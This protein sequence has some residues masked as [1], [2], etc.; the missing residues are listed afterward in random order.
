MPTSYPNQISTI[1]KLITKLNPNS[2]LDVGVGFGKYGVLCREYLELNEDKP[3]YNKFVKKIDGIEVYEK[4]LT[5]LHNY[6]YDHVYVGNV[7]NLIDQMNY[8]Y[9]LV[10]LIDIIEHFDKQQGKN[11]IKKLLKQNKGI[12]ISTPK[13]VSK[14][15]S[16]Y[17]NIY[18]THKSRWTK[19]DFFGFNMPF[20][21]ISDFLSLIVYLGPADE[22]KNLKHWHFKN[23]IA[24]I[25]LVASTYIFL[26]KYLRKF[27]DL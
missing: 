6:I 15:G 20:L 4:Y 14:Q 5:P 24:S 12:F 1:V 22:V 9:D 3:E 2:V 27:Q 11:L 25:P 18:E 17:E 8:N 16:Q 26:N 13:I 21:T 23:Y 19:R 7:L 10:L